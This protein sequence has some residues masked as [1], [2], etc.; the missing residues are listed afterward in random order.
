MS[1]IKQIFHHIYKRVIIKKLTDVKIH[2]GSGDRSSS[3]KNKDP[4]KKNK[5]MFRYDYLGIRNIFVV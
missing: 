5:W 4:A 3:I 2:G 1:N